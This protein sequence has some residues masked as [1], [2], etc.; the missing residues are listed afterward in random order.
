[1]KIIE[2]TNETQVDEAMPKNVSGF[3]T[4]PSKKKPDTKKLPDIE[5][6]NM[7]DHQKAIVD[8]SEA[9]ASGRFPKG[10]STKDLAVWIKKNIMGKTD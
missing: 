8:A 9:P 7:T 10:L 6:E 4:N 1:M 5:Y 3:M 2:I